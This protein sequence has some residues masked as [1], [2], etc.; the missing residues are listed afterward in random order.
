[1]DI[2]AVASTPS[3]KLVHGARVVEEHEQTRPPAVVGGALGVVAE[4][5]R[6]PPKQRRAVRVFAQQRPYH[7]GIEITG[8]LRG[9]H[10]RWLR[11]GVELGRP[12]VPGVGVSPAAVEEGQHG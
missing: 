4:H 11:H 2:P 7:L 1:M 12:R 6:A 3:A 5:V 10:E 9:W 8:Q